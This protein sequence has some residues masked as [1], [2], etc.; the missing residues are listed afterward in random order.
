MLARYAV[1][2]T[3]RCGIT[4]L[5]TAG[6]QAQTDPFPS[7]TGSAVTVFHRIGGYSFGFDRHPFLQRL[8]AF[9]VNCPKGISPGCYAVTAGYR[10]RRSA[11]ARRFHGGIASPPLQ[12]SSPDGTRHCQ[13]EP[14]PAWRT[15]ARH[16]MSCDKRRPC[17]SPQFQPD[18]VQGVSNSKP[19]L[20]ASI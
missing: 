4:H 18:A 17:L 20:Q 7:F 11:P 3:M 13:I 16:G 12:F 9:R 15:T 10:E 14:M 5:D 8:T 6:A 2:S 19:Y 1:T